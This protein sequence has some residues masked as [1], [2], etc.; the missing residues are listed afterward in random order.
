MSIN[1][2][3]VAELKEMKKLGIRVPAK[4]LKNA[5]TADLSEFSNM[6][7]SELA[8]LLIDLA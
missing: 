6:K 5:Q 1:Q 7:I 8:D 3:V 2:E 4:V